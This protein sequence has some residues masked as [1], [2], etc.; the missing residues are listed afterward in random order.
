MHGGLSWLR[1]QIS[2]VSGLAK[3]AAFESANDSCNQDTG[4][5][6]PV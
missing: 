5:Q 2:A 4:P 1:R 3:T 6:G